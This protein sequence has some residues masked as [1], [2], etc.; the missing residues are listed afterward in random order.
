MGIGF[1]EQ[2]KRVEIF[3]LEQFISD[4]WDQQIGA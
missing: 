3:V 2:A 4:N 1:D